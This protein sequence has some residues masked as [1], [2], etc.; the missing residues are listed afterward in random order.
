MKYYRIVLL[1]TIM[2]I[3]GFGA[4]NAAEKTGFDI[5]VS[6]S[7]GMEHTLDDW[8]GNWLILEW[9]NFE[10]PYVKKHYETKNMQ[11]LQKKYTA[12]GVKWLSVCSSAPGNEGYFDNQSINRRIKL[13]QANI[14]MYLVDEK[15]DLARAYNV[16]TTPTIVVINPEGEIMY[17]GSIDDKPTSNKKDIEGA[18]NYLSEIMDAVLKGRP[19]PI[20]ST[21]SYGCPVEYE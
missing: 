11:K 10:C 16:K 2:Y 8:A 12:M 15:G 6:C 20:T 9:V 5:K 7:H 3:L 14:S 19:A 13:Y 21:K 17:Q 18:R 4:L 1:L